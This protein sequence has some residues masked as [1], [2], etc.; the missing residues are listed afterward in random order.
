MSTFLRDVRYG[1]RLLLKSPGFTAVAVITLTLGIGMTTAIFS[2]VYGVLL[3]PLPYEQ[4]DRIVELSEVNDHGGH[5]Q[6]ADPN[7]EDVRSQAR[8]LNGVAEYASE[9]LSV[10]GGTDPTRTMV[11]LVSRDFFSIVRVQPLLGRGFAPEDQRFGAAPVALVGYGYWKQ[12]LGGTADFA[13]RKI[14]VENR[15]VSIIGVLPPQ[16]SFPDAAEIWV[17]R[18]LYERYPSRT[19]HNWRVIGRLR[20]GVT[21]S[22]ARA[23]LQNIATRLKQQYGQDTMMVS[24]GIVPLR[25]ALTSDVRPALWILLGAVGFLLLIACANVA[26]LLLVQSAARQRE[27]AIRFA[28]GA[29]R[30]RVV[31]QLLAEALLLS[32]AGGALGILAAFW[33]VQTLLALSPDALPRAGDVSISAPVLLFSAGLC[34]LVAFALGVFSGLRSSSGIQRALASGGRSQTGEFVSQRLSRAIV[35][36][37][38]AVTLT[39]LTGAVLLGRSLLRV[40]SVDPGFRTENVI[41]MRLAIPEDIVMSGVPQEA[42][43]RRRVQFL[44]ELLSRV[45]AIPG[46]EQVGGTSNLPLIG[47]H[48]DGTYVLMHSGEAVPSNMQALEQLFH[49][50]SR[51][52]DAQYACV[53]AGYFRALDIPLIRGRIFD[54]R[55]T[56]D[57]PHVAVISE[58]LAREKWPGQDPLG[59]QIEFG[60]MDGDV[61]LLT[62][63]GV[64]GDVREE[65]LERPAFPAIYVDYRQRPEATSDF[66]IVIRGTAGAASV[67]SA[68][69]QI[70]RDL[71]PNVPPQF[72]TLE[73]VVSGSLQPRRFNLILVAVFAGTALLLALTGMYG[74]MAYSV[75][76][77]TNEI[78]VRMALGASGTNIFRLVLGQ[79]LLTAIAGVAVGIIAAFAVTRT[80]RSLLFGLNPSDPLTFAVA[81]VLLTIVALLASYLPARRATKVDPMVALRYE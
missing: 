63:V 22:Q 1:M 68:A 56:I 28:L 58:S 77:R 32:L 41:M 12:F 43:K 8:T 19:A 29:T 75:T 76:R 11:A 52:G 66:K 9:V 14:T 3:R 35:A 61:R 18:E 73:Q 37:Q 6:F 42:S 70:V 40:L 30:S 57:S 65:K 47:F 38:L 64:V 44:D 7:F 17:P 15:P 71:D 16:F 67:I 48:P 79:G 62:V 55:D 31:R 25:D 23:D 81:A 20:D 60:N 46:V 51:T 33:G 45:R 74:V 36:G 59:H 72:E 80:M 54:E 5:S 49:D 27:I 53:S 50:N 39:L 4:P 2:V 34:V 78:G 10:S 21:V 13:S 69:R 24:V 26:N